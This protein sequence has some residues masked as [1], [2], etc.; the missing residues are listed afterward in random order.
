MKN[1]TIN[2]T[3]DVGTIHSKLVD[4]QKAIFEEFKVIGNEVVDSEF[5]YIKTTIQNKHGKKYSVLIN[6]TPDGWV[7]FPDKA[8]VA[9][10]E[11]FQMNFPIWRKLYADYKA[12]ERI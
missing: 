9:I 5:D 10:L 4:F 3:E 7:I 6:R 11:E 2:D 1:I 8:D 12:K